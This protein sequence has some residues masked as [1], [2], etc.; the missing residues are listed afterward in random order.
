MKQQHHQRIPYLQQRVLLPQ[1]K[2]RHKRVTI[3][4]WARKVQG[5]TYREIAIL[6]RH[7]SLDGI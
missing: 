6:E 2:G 5:L 3:E 7:E 4:D 1:G